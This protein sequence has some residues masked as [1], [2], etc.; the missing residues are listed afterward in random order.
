M[1]LSTGTK[2]EREKLRSRVSG[3]NSAF[4]IGEQWKANREP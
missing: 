1:N 3:K 2:K 4:S